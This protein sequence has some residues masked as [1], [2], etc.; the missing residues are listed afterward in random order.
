MKAP[1]EK[2]LSIHV[3]ARQKIASECLLVKLIEI[4]SWSGTSHERS[5]KQQRQSDGAISLENYTPRNTKRD[6]GDIW[7]LNSQYFD[8]S[9]LE[10]ECVS[11]RWMDEHFGAHESILG[12]Y[13]AS[14]TTGETITR[15]I[16]DVLLRS[17]LP[18]A[19]LRGQTF[20]GAGNMSGPQKGAQALLG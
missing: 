14:P 19:S 11:V 12:F 7:T 16:R 3:A 2:Q 9:G 6:A 8:V 15:P 18:L 5:L 4:P 13:Q 10:P 1:L 20:D 17:Q